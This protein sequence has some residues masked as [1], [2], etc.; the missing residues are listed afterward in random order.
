MKKQIE[1]IL[2][3]PRYDKYREDIEDNKMQK[4][5]SLS[6]RMLEVWLL[7]LT[8]LTSVI[9]VLSMAN[10]FLVFVSI[11][12]IG[13]IVYS[14]KKFH[15]A[16]SCYDKITLQHDGYDALSV[17]IWFDSHFSLWYQWLVYSF[18]Y[19]LLN[20]YSLINEDQSTAETSESSYRYLGTDTFRDG[21]M[22]G[23]GTWLESTISIILT[24][25]FYLPATMVASQYNY[26]RSMCGSAFSTL[27]VL[28]SVI[29]LNNNNMFANLWQ[30]MARV[31][32][33]GIIFLL[34]ITRQRTAREITIR[35]TRGP[36]RWQETD[37]DQTRSVDRN[38]T[39]GLHIHSEDYHDVEKVAGNRI[40][41]SLFYIL[42]GH[43]YTSACFLVL[44]ICVLIHK[45]VK[46]YARKSE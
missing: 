12:S 18:G 27:V 40:Y 36:G 4:L 46:N 14:I 3:P 6:T 37:S 44:H 30:S 33:S 16:P 10:T 28:T 2:F 25:V 34:I 5:N 42:Y 39:P 43:F 41:M 1:S 11:L 21:I 19:H 38:D 35:F 29:P 17:W 26:G 32:V 20:Q 24:L 7:V 22:V 23:E 15:S 8:L 13:S 45:I 9:L 31:F